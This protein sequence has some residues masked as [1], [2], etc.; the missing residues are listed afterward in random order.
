V[1]QDHYILLSEQ[2][3]HESLIRTKFIGCLIRISRKKDYFE[4][5]KINSNQSPF[6]D[7]FLTFYHDDIKTFFPDFHFSS[8]EPKSVIFVLR[9][10]L[11]VGLFIF[12]PHSVDTLEIDLDY[13]IPD[14]RD[15]KTAHFFYQSYDQ[16]LEN[17]SCKY[18]VTHSNIKKHVKYLNKLGF[19]KDL[20]KGTGW[21][22][23]SIRN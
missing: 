19:Q 15:L 5:F 20:E 9:N 12:R 6:L 1:R 18:F 23:K 17:M 4:L 7:R 16:Q 8:E 10:L 11:P 14:Y 13:V 3:V 22:K 2:Q 21:F